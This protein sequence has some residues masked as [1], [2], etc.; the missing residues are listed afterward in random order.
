MFI[1]LHMLHD[2]RKLMLNINNIQCVGQLDGI[3]YIDFGDD[4]F[5]VK[6][7]YEQIRHA[8]CKIALIESVESEDNKNGK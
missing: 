4:I 8:I 6:E 7:S 1:E 5:Q 2:N 3:T